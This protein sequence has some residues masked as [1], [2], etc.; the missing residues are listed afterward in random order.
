[1]LPWENEA[2]E[3]LMSILDSIEGISILGIIPKGDVGQAI[4][5][6]FS[7]WLNTAEGRFAVYRAENGAR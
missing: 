2:L 1:M 7:K 5:D 3:K 4:V 6:D